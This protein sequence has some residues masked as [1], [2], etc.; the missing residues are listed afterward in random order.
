MLFMAQEFLE[1]KLWSENPTRADHFIDWEAMATDR[2]RTDSSMQEVELVA[3]NARG[4]DVHQLDAF[5]QQVPRQL[6]SNAT[7]TA[8]HLACAYATLIG[9]RATTGVDVEL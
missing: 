3:V 4:L 6:N 2:T 5:G 1:V 7:V 9:L 8:P